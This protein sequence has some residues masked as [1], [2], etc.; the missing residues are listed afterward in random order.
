MEPQ[1][2]SL[3]D[4]M[5]SPEETMQM[6][7]T[8]QQPQSLRQPDFMQGMPSPEET[9]QHL[10]KLGIDPNNFG[11][12]DVRTQETPGAEQQRLEKEWRAPQAQEFAQQPGMAFNPVWNGV[13]TAGRRGMATVLGAPNSISQFV[14]GP[15]IGP[16]KRMADVFEN[17]IKAKDEAYQIKYGHPAP[18]YEKLTEGVSTSLTEIATV[19]AKV[20]RA[21]YL[22]YAGENA[23]R[24]ALQEADEHNI[25]GFKRW[26]YASVNAG[27]EVATEFIF[28]EAGKGALAEATGLKKIVKPALLHMLKT[29]GEEGAEEGINQ[30]GQNLNKMVHG[31]PMFVADPS[32]PGG[33]RQ[34]QPTSS[35]SDFAQYL[36]DGVPMATGAGS[37]TGGFIAGHHVAQEHFAGQ[38]QITPQNPTGQQSAPNAPQAP[39]AN[40][41]AQTPPRPDLGP[42]PPTNPPPAATPPEIAHAPM[43]QPEQPVAAPVAQEAQQ[44][45]AEAQAPQAEPEGAQ[46][47]VSEEQKRH[48]GQR[49]AELRDALLASGKNNKQV[50]KI[51]DGM[52]P[53]QIDDELA[54]LSPKVEVPLQPAETRPPEVQPVTTPIENRQYQTGQASPQ[55]KI[56]PAIQADIDTAKRL[57]IIDAIKSVYG[58]VH[59]K[60]GYKLGA[61]EVAK[62]SQDQ[63]KKLDPSLTNSDVARIV[64]AVVGDPDWHRMAPAR[65]A[66]ATAA[67]PAPV[68]QPKEPKLKGVAP[69]RGEN[70]RPK[71]PTVVAEQKPAEQPKPA[72]EK[73][74]AQPLFAMEPERG[75]FGKQ[76]Q[77]V[78]TI[79]TLQPEKKP[80]E[81]VT[82]E[83]PL[84]KSVVKQAETLPGQMSLEMKPA[85]EPLREPDVE[86]KQAKAEKRKKR[87]ASRSERLNISELAHGHGLK[88]DELLAAVDKEAAKDSE[89]WNNLNEIVKNHKIKSDA[90]RQKLQEGDETNLPKKRFD[91][92]QDAI[93]TGEHRHSGVTYDEVL[94]AIKN[95]MPPKPSAQNREYVRE[96]AQVLSRGEAHDEDLPDYVPPTEGDILFH[97]GS[98]PPLTPSAKSSASVPLNEREV[99]DAIGKV[100]EVPTFRGRVKKNAN[101]QYQ[102]S[103]KVIRL[104]SGLWSNVVLMTHEIGH[105]IE[106][107]HNTLRHILGGSAAAQSELLSLDPAG[108][109]A[110]EGFAEF[111]R[112]YLTLDDAPMVAPQA[113][114]EFTKQ[115]A[116]DTNLKK[117]VDEA[118]SLIDTL[119]DRNPLDVV[120]SQQ[121]QG[122]PIID[123]EKDKGFWDNVKDKWGNWSQN[124]L[125]WMHNRE[126]RVLKA[127]RTADEKR[128]T[129]PELFY[130]LWNRLTG[131]DYKHTQHDLGYGVHSIDGKKLSKSMQE[132][133]KA[134]APAEVDEFKATY[135]ALDGLDRIAR[136]PGYTPGRTEQEYQDL[137]AEV[138]KDP[139]KLKRFEQAALDMTEY[140]HALQEKQSM[141]G[142]KSKEEYERI[143]KSPN[144]YFMPRVRTQTHGVDR[145]VNRIMGG[146]S[147]FLNVK[148]TAKRMSAKG[149]T[150]QYLPLEEAIVKETADA[151]RVAV[152]MTMAAS[153][154]RRLLPGLGGIDGMGDIITQVDPKSKL[155]E[156]NLGRIIDQLTADKDKNG[157]AIA[158]LL[159]PDEGQL[160]KDVGELRGG[161]ISNSAL[162]RLEALYGTKD[163]TALMHATHDVRSLR[164]TIAFWKQD[165]GTSEKE[166]V[167]FIHLDGQDIGVQIKDESL[168][169]AM[170]GMRNVG[171][172]DIY[173]MLYTSI[174]D[175]F[176]HRITGPLQSITV[177]MN[178]TAVAALFP[179]DYMG[180]LLQSKHTGAAER[181]YAP[182]GN[183]ARL[184]A[185]MA[186]EDFHGHT[187]KWAQ[188]IIG[189][190]TPEAAKR[191]VKAGMILRHTQSEE[192]GTVASNKLFGS[193]RMTT[194]NMTK[195][196]MPEQKQANWYRTAKEHIGP[197][198]EMY[199]DW[200][201]MPDSGIRL[202]EMVGYARSK[203]YTINKNVSFADIEAGKNGWL[204]PTGIPVDSPVGNVLNGML[205]HNNEVITNYKPKG[206]VAVEVGKF[207]PFFTARMAGLLKEV[208]TASEMA[209][210]LGR[211]VTGKASNV[212]AFGPRLTA[213]AATA[214]AA[215]MYW[216]FNHDDD[217]RKDMDPAIANRFWTFSH[218]GIPYAKLAKPRAY[219]IFINAIEGLLDAVVDRRDPHILEKLG[220]EAQELSPVNS[221]NPMNWPAGISTLYQLATNQDWAGRPIDDRWQAEAGI[222]P[223]HRTRPFTLGT[224]GFLS[225]FF[226]KY[227]GLSPAK[228]EYLLNQATGTM[229]SDVVGT[230]EKAATGTLDRQTFPIIRRQMT[231]GLYQRSTSE[232]YDQHRDIAGK[233]ATAKHIGLEDDQTKLDAE[234]L[235]QLDRYKGV[236]S[237]IRKSSAASRGSFDDKLKLEKYAVGM[238][239]YALGKTER[240]SF[241]NPLKNTKTVVPSEVADERKKFVLSLAHAITSNPSVKAIR[242]KEQANKFPARLDA[243]KVQR[244]WA[245]GELKRL[246][247]SVADVARIVLAENAKKGMKTAPETIGELVV[248]MS[249]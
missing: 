100:F 8:L 9:M 244:E 43:P 156:T 138:G 163:Q 217:D 96:I 52:T 158:P 235:R 116:A 85:E 190:V 182:L 193:G 18:W 121:L 46:P 120:L 226:T 221:W 232:F 11:A 26:G 74:H 177:G 13:I 31:M 99:V 75:L 151:N 233:V 69:F 32:S 109:S 170:R 35:V 131:S 234:H 214:T 184:A 14:G 118:R 30:F 22:A 40:A 165:F 62:E 101:G 191:E 212:Q 66:E 137:L 28:S 122:Q 208:S 229:Y 97:K 103:D 180:F 78:G 2:A 129:D 77:K 49:K 207:V 200:M 23:F 15:E 248:G 56:T 45:P 216:W 10:Q 76:P 38:P 110:E 44:A 50:K 145:V 231:K 187:P 67:E 185:A 237:A 181:F 79:E 143:V 243:A 113:Y 94:D 213:M 161:K 239:D 215:A 141:A 249:R 24:N 242:T 1:L 36:F 224:S 4:G 123:L 246:G 82:Q 188:D 95:G 157:K 136:V 168:W 210:G 230:T 107:S 89:Y 225:H 241:P 203:G 223:E 130:N 51:I 219:G 178:P 167:M 42:E 39:P 220:V 135:D 162:T 83:A 195:L 126:S 124:Y 88:P 87:E 149:S 206:S 80:A 92:L 16:S 90:H 20:G 53:V 247:Y 201:A 204:N 68:E 59:H 144:K 186:Y 111:M 197:G 218:D 171:D 58:K 29:A 102:T 104:A 166:H 105:A 84:D 174:A 57:G 173:S 3:L 12:M 86:R 196:F 164:D 55:Q 21:P 199:R 245:A 205:R 112:H 119:R 73:T 160:I 71:P 140:F 19:A 37:L 238:A 17:Q 209:G 64:M 114:A 240:D 25:T 125:D 41:T 127:A 172:A 70:I 61:L 106:K 183:I 198:M 134:I 60:Y 228:T 65:P 152:Q 108:K 128:G 176:R 227:A 5:P 7:S 27:L 34:L 146:P 117:K 192:A 33:R 202:A 48:D 159:D 6:V 147:G 142:A 63:I 211:V 236:I 72:T 98:V 93:E 155:T 153:F 179:M 133:W 81:P 115:L 91:E 222:A 148:G 150:D 154:L 175:G 54:K 47:T 169:K 139:A 132:I 189:A 194:K